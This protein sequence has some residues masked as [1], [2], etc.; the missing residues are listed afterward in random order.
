MVPKWPQYNYN[1]FCKNKYEIVTNWSRNWAEKRNS[2][3]GLDFSVLIC[4]PNIGWYWLINTRVPKKIPDW[5]V[6]SFRGRLFLAQKKIAWKIALKI[7]FF[8]SI[9]DFRLSSI[10]FSS[11]IFSSISCHSAKH[12]LCSEEGKLCFG[13]LPEFHIKIHFYHLFHDMLLF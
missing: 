8:F 5:F 3:P 9:S 7:D 10:D 11:F 6:T 13:Y 1:V 4:S 12:L 2:E